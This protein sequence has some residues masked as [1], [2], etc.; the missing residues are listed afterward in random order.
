ML[1]DPKGKSKQAEPS[2]AKASEDKIIINNYLASSKLSPAARLSAVALREGGR[3]QSQNVS[4]ETFCCSVLGRIDTE[5]L[6][7]DSKA[8]IRDLPDRA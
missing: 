7:G 3:M 5:R 1:D 8:Q 6:I 2:Y 4:G